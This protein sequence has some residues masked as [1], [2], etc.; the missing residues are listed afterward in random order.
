MFF[1]I[2]DSGEAVLMQD[3]HSAVRFLTDNEYVVT[4]SF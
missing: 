1:I 4:L 3:M 2:T